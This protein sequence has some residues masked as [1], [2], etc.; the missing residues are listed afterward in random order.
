MALIVLLASACP[1]LAY[2]DQDFQVWSTFSVIHDTDPWHFKLEEE[3]YFKN[4]ARDLEY[5][6]T[7]VGAWCTI[8]PQME[9]GLAY[10]QIEAMSKGDWKTEY[11]P[12]GYFT[13]RAEAQGLKLDDRNRVEY[14]ILED[15]D[16]IVCYRNRLTA[17]YPVKVGGFDME[18]Y[19]S[20]EAFIDT[21]QGRW[22]QFRSILGVR[23][24]LSAWARLDVYYL[25]Q[26]V[27]KKT[28]WLDAHIFGTSL[29][30]KL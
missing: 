16:D 13:L 12:L 9:A 21:D 4:D 2:D 23:K 6:H 27:D 30:F 1:L 20:E 22:N 24:K 7:E 26:T 19:A 14:K 25:W 18:P 28:M 11:R 17:A 5:Q 3:V 10:R 15:Q 29:S 8:S